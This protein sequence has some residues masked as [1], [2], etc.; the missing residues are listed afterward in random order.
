VAVLIQEL[1]AVR[2]IK[3]MGVCAV[4]GVTH[5]QN[6]R[7]PCRFPDEVETGAV[8]GVCCWKRPSSVTQRRRRSTYDFPVADSRTTAS[9][10]V[11]PAHTN[12][13]TVG[14][15]FENV[16]A[17]RRGERERVDG[18]DNEFLGAVQISV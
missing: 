10:A 18:A 1:S 14:G 13:S 5:T 9:A 8:L 15:L 12:G 4:R 6:R 2:K 3:S 7:H 11:E 16:A 17:V